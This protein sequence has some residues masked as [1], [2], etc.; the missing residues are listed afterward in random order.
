MNIRRRWKELKPD[1]RDYVRIYAWGVLW[2]TWFF[3]FTPNT[4]TFLD[5]PAALI[6]SASGV[7]GGLIAL[8]AVFNKDP[9]LLE[10]LGVG[11]LVVAPFAYSFVQAVAVGIEL[12]TQGSTQRS[13]LIL[14][15][16][17]PVLFLHKRRRQIRDMVK[18]AKETTLPSEEEE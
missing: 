7:V 11:L 18:A 16:I 12:V 2:S 14:L 17:W 5:K 6:L 15:G 10:R 13:H 9:L 4:L 1:Q 3:L 8:V